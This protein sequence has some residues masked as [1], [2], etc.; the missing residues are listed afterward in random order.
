MEFGVW[1]AFFALFIAGGL[2]PGPAVMLVTTSS[3]RYGFWPSMAPAIGICVSNLI[4]VTLAASGASALAHA[5]PQAFTALKLAGVAFILWLA[6][7]TAFGAPV[8]LLR[9]EPPPK[10]KLFA[11][12]VGLQLA[13]PNALVYF[14]GLM[15][16]YLDTSRDLTTQAIVI[17][18]TVTVCEMFGLIIYAL[19][20]DALAR[21]FQSQTFATWFFRLAALAMAA[22]ASFAVYATWAA[23]GR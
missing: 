1:F 19:G 22:S 7:R 6:W 12:G 9:R 20:A 10:A 18:I 4:W 8:D 2:T 17:M 3:I 21:R 13:N 5:F 11:H 23:T 16:A 14:G 15:P